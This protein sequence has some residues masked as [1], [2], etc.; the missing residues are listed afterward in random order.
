MS[1]CKPTNEKLLRQL[2]IVKNFCYRSCFGK[3]ETNRTQI[4][5]FFSNLEP[6]E[7]KILQEFLDFLHPVESSLK[8]SL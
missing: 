4:E 3:V 7:S 2:Y 6:V 8:L 5:V 1:F